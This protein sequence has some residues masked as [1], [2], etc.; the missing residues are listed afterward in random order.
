MQAIHIGQGLRDRDW[1]RAIGAA[2]SALLV[3]V[4]HKENFKKLLAGTES[5]FSLHS[6]PKE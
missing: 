2:L 4:R 5:K 1:P 3:I 6:K